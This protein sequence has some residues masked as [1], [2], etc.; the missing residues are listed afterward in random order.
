MQ[1][2]VPVI[3][4]NLSALRWLCLLRLGLRLWL[5][6]FV[7]F[8]SGAAHSFPFGGLLKGGEYIHQSELVTGAVYA[9]DIIKGE[10][11]APILVE[12][13]LEGNEV[14]AL[15]EHSG[16]YAD[17]RI[18]SITE[19]NG[20]LLLREKVENLYAQKFVL[21]KRNAYENSLLLDQ[22]GNPINKKALLPD[23]LFVWI[24]KQ[25][26]IVPDENYIL[27]EV[28]VD[29]YLSPFTV[30]LNTLR[31]LLVSNTSGKIIYKS[32]NNIGYRTGFI[33]NPK[34]GEQSTFRRKFDDELLN[35]IAYAKVFAAASGKEFTS[36]T[37]ELGKYRI[38]YF[39]PPCPGIEITYHNPIIAELHYSRFHPGK[40]ERDIYGCPAY[41]NCFPVKL[42]HFY[43]T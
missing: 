35:P 25:E 40:K 37:D 13:D 23:T 18:M 8:A 34:S 26:F 27:L 21:L 14:K 41:V 3:Q 5:V 42:F 38:E 11:D 32:H 19:Y 6:L 36:T 10:N 39:N 1:W 31:S 16:R 30:E 7:I 24:L 29:P 15:G 22:D 4:L 20:Y 28:P 9:R 12:Y 33:V 43:Y 17:T 2:Y